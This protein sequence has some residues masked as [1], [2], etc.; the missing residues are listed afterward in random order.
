[1]CASGWLADDMKSIEVLSTENEVRKQSARSPKVSVVLLNLNG[2]EDTRDCLESLRHVQYT[3][4]ET[5][6]VDNGS[7]D[8]SALRLQKEFPELRLLSSKENLGFAGGSN[9]GIEDALRRNTD[10]V[11]LL[12]NDTVVDPNFLPYLLEI[13]ETD[14]RIGILGPKILYADDPQRIWF[15]GGFVRLRSGAYGHFGLNNLDE[16]GKFSHVE[17][18]GWITG[19]ALLVKTSAFREAGLLDSRLFAYSEDADFC[20]RVRRAGYKC[21]FVPRAR[22]WHKIARTSGIQSPFSV[23]L[24][25]RNQLTWV[26]RHVPFPYKLGALPFTLLKKMVRA[27]L[28]AF[29]RPELALAVWAGLRAF[30]LQKYGPPGEGRLPRRHLGSTAPNRND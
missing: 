27:A 29:D 18:T 4:I 19:C 7:S 22:V 15:A 26:A 5:I 30:L 10:Y 1:M 6:V 8:D 17:E 3:N 14:S 24:V 16:D 21:I 2:Y 20:M 9:L 25:T 13:G 11:L 28:L 12:N 23:Y